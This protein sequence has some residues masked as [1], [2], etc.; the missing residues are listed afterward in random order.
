MKYIY[1]RGGAPLLKWRNSAPQQSRASDAKSLGG[2]ESF[3]GGQ[4]VR[5][6]GA[7]VGQASGL[8]CGG[9]GKGLGS[10]EGS[11]LDGPTVS[12]PLPRPGAPEPLPS[13]GSYSPVY[14]SDGGFRHPMRG[15]FGAVPEAS[16][17]NIAIGV[18][19]AYALYKIFGK[20]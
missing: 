5:V 6:A 20:K 19:V 10:L 17:R 18:G 13:M 8:G 12:M 15:P 3:P 16:P 9:C 4:L 7:R 14:E 2:Y 1:Q 11:S